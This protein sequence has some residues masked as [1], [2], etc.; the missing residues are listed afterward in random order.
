M[1][2]H[3]AYFP[4]LTADR[5]DALAIERRE[6]ADLFA[7]S[8]LRPETIHLLGGREEIHSWTGHGDSGFAAR[9]GALTVGR[10]HVHPFRALRDDEHAS[11]YYARVAGVRPLRRPLAVGEAARRWAEEILSAHRRA[12]IVHAGSGGRRKNWSGMEQIARRWSEGEGDVLQLI[13][14]SEGEERGFGFAKVLRDQPLDHVAALLRAANC[15]LGNDSG[16][17]HLAAAAGARGLALFGPTCARQW[18]PRGGGMRS[19]VATRTC[20]SCADVF[21]I[22]RLEVDAVWQALLALPRAATK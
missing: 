21:C 11:D 1:V 5:I 18:A 12:L 3:P 7:S 9:L 20:S 10:A 6:I 8:P 4:L 15:Y 22:H 19:I 17:S 14:P 16:I 2:T 13:G